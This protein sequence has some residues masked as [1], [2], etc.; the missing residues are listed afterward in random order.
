M[1][2]SITN[3]RKQIEKSRP[4]FI[5]VVI[6]SHGHQ[7]ARTGNDEVMDIHM[8]GIPIYKIKNSLIDGNRCPAMIGKPKL[9]FIQACRTKEAEILK[10]NQTLFSTPLYYNE[11][12]RIKSSKSGTN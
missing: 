10:M 4:D 11:R 1:F 8:N 9:F 2:R 12:V 5:V 7:N 3:F 6:L